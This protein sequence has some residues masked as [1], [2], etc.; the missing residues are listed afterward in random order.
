VSDRL[1]VIDR[2]LWV[3]M[4]LP[5]PAAE[6]H[7]ASLV[8]TLKSDI[9]PAAATNKTAGQPKTI[10]IPSSRIARSG[11]SSPIAQVAQANNPRGTCTSSFLTANLNREKS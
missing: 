11:S 1:E 3:A 5:Q 8:L 10:G 9:W 7:Q 2:P 6:G 4:R